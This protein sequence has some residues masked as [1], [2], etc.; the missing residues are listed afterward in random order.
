MA[1]GGGWQ[2]RR[3]GGRDGAWQRRREG[4]R[5]AGTIYTN[6]NRKQKLH[7][8]QSQNCTFFPL[9]QTKI[10]HKKVIV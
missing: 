3:E 10:V 1:N 7:F 2:R 9:N 4:G 5:G 6:I 8:L